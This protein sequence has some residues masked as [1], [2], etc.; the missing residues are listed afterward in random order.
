MDLRAV[1]LAEPK[2]VQVY[3]DEASAR[4]YRDTGRHPSPLLPQTQF[5]PSRSSLLNWD[6]KAWEIVNRGES[7]IWLKDD[8]GSVISLSEQTLSNLLS[9]GSANF[10]SA[11]SPAS[12]TDS[13]SAKELLAQS[14]AADMAE[15][16]RR[17][18]IL[19]A[20]RADGWNQELGVTLRTI[21]RWEADVRLA[22]AVYQCGYAGLLPRIRNSGNRTPRLPEETR[23]LMEEYVARE[24]ENERQPTRFAVWSKLLR[25]CESRSL[26]APSYRAFCQFVGRRPRY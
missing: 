23:K 16:N 21:Q 9:Q 6:G 4:L 12:E 8:A 10:I 13:R 24:Y 5:N 22:E 26:S 14:S 20:Y 1:P 18:A 3:F 2:R 11:P 7:N 17:Y 15:A 19:T 25:E